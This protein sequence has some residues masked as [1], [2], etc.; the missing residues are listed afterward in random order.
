MKFDESR[1]QPAGFFQALPSVAFPAIAFGLLL[2]LLG[3]GFHPPLFAEEPLLSSFGTGPARVILY[4]DYFCPPCRGL[5][6]RLEPLIVDLMNQSA[7][8][9]IFVDTPIHPQSPV[10]AR[11]FLYALNFKKDFQ[12]A[13]F[14]RSAL[15]EAAENQI[16]EK[17]K[18]G[19][20]IRKKGIEFIPF[21][22][23]SILAVWNRTLQEDKIDS[24][25]T[26]MIQRGIKKEIFKGPVDILKALQEL[27]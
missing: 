8:H 4:T 11:Q 26:I 17:K 18:L 5:E 1:K 25:P 3:M 24:T 2:F 22:V 15:F 20:F 16:I 13:L 12:H 19:E 23:S 21:D 6:P 9:L 10:Y 27:K 14:V 7:I